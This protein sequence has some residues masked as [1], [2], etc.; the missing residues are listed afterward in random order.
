MT[1]SYT[2]VIIVFLCDTITARCFLKITAFIFRIELN[3]AHNDIIRFVAASRH[4]NIEMFGFS[5]AK[6]KI[7]TKCVTKSII[8]GWLYNKYS[9][10]VNLFKQFQHV[11][12]CSRFIL[13]SWLTISCFKKYVILHVINYNRR[14]GVELSPRTREI[15]V[16]FPA[17]PDPCH[18]NR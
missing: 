8:V 1:V 15:G 17:A 3:I 6:C 10:I 13:K 14:S 4:R 7:F 9:F 11:Y 16:R 18:K 2:F 5:F 12:G